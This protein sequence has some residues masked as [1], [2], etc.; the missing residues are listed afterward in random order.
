MNKFT[1]VIANI[2]GGLIYVLSLLPM[3]VQYAFSDCIYAVLYYII[4]YRRKIVRRNLQESF[5][6]MDEATRLQTE[7]KFY[8]WLCDYVVETFK[9]LSIGDEEMRRRMTFPDIEKVNK[10]IGEGK[11]V[12][13]FLGHYCNWE[14]VST[15]PLWVTSPDCQCGELYHPLR[16]AVVDKIF[17][18]LRQR[19]HT[20][21]IPKKESIRQ[22]IRYMR[23]GK[24]VVIGYIADQKPKWRDIHLWLPFLNHPETPVFTGS[25]RII[26]H[27][28]QVPF[29]CEMSRPKRGYYVC[30]FKE[31][32]LLA[33]PK[34][35]SSGDKKAAGEGSTADFP[36]T[37]MYMKMLEENI[38]RHPEYYLWSHDRWSRT[39]EEFDRRY[40]VENGKV[41]NRQ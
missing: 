6:E 34:T 2:L 5:P 39:R 28:K 37:R 26:E 21:C 14:W 3:R 32:T 29:Y 22:I 20:V 40:Y 7:R 38:R 23:D 25:E 16:N 31:M 11:S 19:F 12:A 30:E 33:Q 8:H 9:L 27:T 36:L 1:S 13:L 4:R 18:R 41:Y 15:L 10:L 35:S 17:L 24:S